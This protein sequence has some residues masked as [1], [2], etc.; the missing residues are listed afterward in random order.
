MC[1]AP[2][3]QNATNTSMYRQVRGVVAWAAKLHRVG[4]ALPRNVDQQGEGGREQQPC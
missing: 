2:Q 4:F 1:G 3:K